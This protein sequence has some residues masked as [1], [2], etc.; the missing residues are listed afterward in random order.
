[1]QDEQA[2]GWGELVLFVKHLLGFIQCCAKVKTDW[3][4]SEDKRIA[5]CFRQQMGTGFKP[6]LC[7]SFPSSLRPSTFPLPNRD[8]KPP[9]VRLD[10]KRVGAGAVSEC[11][12]RARYKG[13]L[14]SLCY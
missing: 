3:R 13:E 12:R 1:M 5:L 9:F 7:P 8:R 14:I 4:H 2:K 10:C 6:Q 11:L